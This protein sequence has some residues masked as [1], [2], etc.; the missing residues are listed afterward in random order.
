MRPCC[1][2]LL[3]VAALLLTPQVWASDFTVTVP[4]DLSRIPAAYPH[5]QVKCW[6]LCTGEE[7]S[8]QSTNLQE[9]IVPLYT[10]WERVSPGAW[11]NVPGYQP[12][13]RWRGTTVEV[14]GMGATE[15]TIPPTVGEYHSN[16]TVRFDAFAGYAP[17]NVRSYVCGMKISQDATHWEPATLDPSD[18]SRLAQG[19]TTPVFFSTGLFN[20]P[21]ADTSQ[22]NVSCTAP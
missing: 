16:V 14:V 6:A 15:A 19:Q 9:I 8:S 3:T 12:T 22:P 11:G 1:I 10:D 4:V 17:D 5:L 18:T 20:N 2:S 21:A 13:V 7:P